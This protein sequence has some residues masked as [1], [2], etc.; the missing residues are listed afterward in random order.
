MNET[1][2]TPETSSL[3]IIDPKNTLTGFFLI[4]IGTL[5]K[6]DETPDNIRLGTFMPKAEWDCFRGEVIKRLKT[7]E[8]HHYHTVADRYIGQLLCGLVEPGYLG[9]GFRLT[10]PNGL[11]ALSFLKQSA[12]MDRE[13]N[14]IYL[15]IEKQINESK[16]TAAKETAGKIS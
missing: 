11:E 5:N 2:I 8:E 10:N 13:L 6:W 4:T 1:L 16:A 15:G 14:Y 12:E 9:I 3:Q 7:G